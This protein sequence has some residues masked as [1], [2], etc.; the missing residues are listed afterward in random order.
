MILKCSDTAEVFRVI[1]DLGRES[2]ET[3]AR[4]DSQTNLDMRALELYVGHDWNTEV[5]Q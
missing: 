2:W 1:D 5:S 4:I 3:H